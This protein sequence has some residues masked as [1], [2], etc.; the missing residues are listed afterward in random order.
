[1]VDLEF[2]E[3]WIDQRSAPRAGGIDFLEAGES[4]KCTDL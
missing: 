4:A 3:V 2:I 1:M